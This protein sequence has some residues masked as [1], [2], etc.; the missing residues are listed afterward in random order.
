LVSSPALDAKLE[1]FVRLAID[2]SATHLYAPGIRRH[3]RRALELDASREEILEVIKLMSVVG[4][5]AP[6]TGF[7]ILQQELA[8]AGSSGA[9]E[10]PPGHTPTCDWF[11]SHD[12]FNPDWELLYQWTP[13]WLESFLSLAAPIWRDRILPP[14]WIELLC[15]A[16]DAALTHMYDP[17][18]RRHIRAALDLGATREQL[19]R[20]LQIVA[21]QAQESYEVAAPI[22]DQECAAYGLVTGHAA[23]RILVHGG[24]GPRSDR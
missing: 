6:A 24:T 20:V 14:L 2:A 23:H 21:E 19:L 1:A 13:D 11:R 3:I 18:T 5:H 16:A 7:P 15:V 4:V 17:G 22:L 12:Q 10:P 9:V 8:R